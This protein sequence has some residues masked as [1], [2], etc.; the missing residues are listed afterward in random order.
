[1]SGRAPRVAAT[2][3]AA[4]LLA[5]AAGTVA[6]SAPSVDQRTDAAQVAEPAWMRALRIRGEALNRIYGLAPMHALEIRGE[7]LNRMYG[8]DDGGR[9]QAGG[10]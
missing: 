9:R 6:V 8:L 2:I 1:M 5:G 3:A 4:G 10:S 7:A